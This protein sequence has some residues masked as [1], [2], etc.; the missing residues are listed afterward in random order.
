M[1][2]RKCPNCGAWNSGDLKYCSNC[3]ALIEP[4]AIAQKE[5]IE[6]R[7]KRK[8]EALKNASKF[9]LWLDSLKDSPKV[10]NRI[11]Y[12]V[13]HVLFTIQMA[14]MS[15]FIWLIALISG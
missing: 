7:Q 5:Q 12:R 15:F 9:E 11:L 2:E 1:N 10:F 14:I 3:N 8:E 4:V 6:A 13:L